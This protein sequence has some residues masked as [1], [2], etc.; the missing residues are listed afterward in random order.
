M[1]EPRFSST[2]RTPGVC[3]HTETSFAYV[4]SAGELVTIGE[5]SGARTYSKPAVKSSAISLPPSYNVVRA[6]ME[7]IPAHRDRFPAAYRLPPGLRLSRFEQTQT[8]QLL[9]Y[10][11]EYFCTSPA[12]SVLVLGHRY[13]IAS[14]EWIANYVIV[15]FHNPSAFEV[16]I[17]SRTDRQRYSASMRPVATAYS[18]TN[19]TTVESDV[20][21]FF[22]RNCTYSVVERSPAGYAGVAFELI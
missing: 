17:S 1:D 4:N 18:S 8:H 5:P 19:F 13:V 2:L 15:P 12:D 7:V 3:C 14:V 10:G 20:A 11:D 22:G 6:I 9:R 16:Y 21:L